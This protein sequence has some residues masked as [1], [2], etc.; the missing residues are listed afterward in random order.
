MGTPVVC[1]T[2]DALAEA[3]SVGVSEVGEVMI[4]Y[5]T[6][7][8]TLAIVDKQEYQ[9][10]T[11]TS[12]GINA[13]IFPGTYH[14][15]ANLTTAG[16]IMRWLRDLTRSSF[17]DLI[18]SARTVGVGADGLMMLPHF[19][20]M[21]TPIFRPHA[22]GA[23]VG[24]TLQHTPGHLYKAALE[25][26]A[27]GL[28]HNFEAMIKSGARPTRC[29]AVGGGTRG[30]LWAQVVSDVLQVQQIIP[31]NTVGAAFG[32]ALL[33]GISVELVNSFHDWNPADTTINPD[34]A[35]ADRYKTLYGHYLDLY[36]LLDNAD[37]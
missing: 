35:V 4:M 12:I 22:R 7:L 25:G 36:H 18:D 30:G 10:G 27:Y 23:I 16:A 21:R 26:T 2:I 14:L 20:G 8:L 17:D 6:T 1:G 31:K 3:C 24:L 37:A 13:G 33:A 19:A 11:G 28:R 32:D 29:V 9:G 34:P 15:N 5:G